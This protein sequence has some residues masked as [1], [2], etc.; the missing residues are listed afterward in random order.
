[1]RRATRHAGMRNSHIAN[2]FDEGGAQR[3]GRVKKKSKKSKI[4]CCKK[5]GATKNAAKKQRKRKERAR[6]YVRFRLAR[7]RAFLF[8]SG[9]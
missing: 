6:A 9:M 4:G 8:Q 1:M 2:A 5:G 7:P 3:D